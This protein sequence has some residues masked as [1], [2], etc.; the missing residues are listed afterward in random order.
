V[1]QA[2]QTHANPV[3]LYERRCGDAKKPLG[4][5]AYQRHEPQNTVLYQLVEEHLNTLLLDAQL[6]SEHGYGY[7]QFVEKTFRNYVDCGRLELGFCR[8]V[9]PSCGYERLRAFSCK[10]RGVCP[11]CDA[12][13]MNDSAAH[14]VDRV[15]PTAP[16]RQFVLTFPI[17][18][19]LLLL[20]DPKLLSFALSTFTRRLFAWQRRIARSMGI[21]DPQCGAVTFVQRWGSAL[22]ANPHFHSVIPDGV[23][24][25][26]ADGTVRFVPL[27]GPDDEDVKRIVEQVKKRI[28]AKVEHLTEDID[29]DTDEG[30]PHTLELALAP[31]PRRR[32]DDGWEHPQAE[33]KLCCHLDGYSLHAATTVNA[34]DRAGLERLCRY[35]LRASF[36]L[37]RLSLLPTVTCG[38]DS[39]ERGLMAARTSCCL[40][41]RFCAAS[42]HSFHRS[43]FIPSVIMAYFR[44]HRFCDPISFHVSNLRN[45][46]PVTHRCAPP[47]VHHPMPPRSLWPPSW[48]Q[49][50]APT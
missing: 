19:R 48:Q 37:N 18:V 15:L 45:P 35:G 41:C 26:T 31:G 17:Q 22:N 3:L 42:Q 21:K 5:G 7:P 32:P 2:T 25:Q 16:Y 38:I 9:C 44:P 29:P 24:E 27:L 23:F 49:A 47:T 28:D 46:P 34:E 1:A 8:V 36:S 13:R 43:A 11:S 12:R 50:S 30:G 6:R 14:L 40:P 20:R 10:C 33:K 39:N 4:Q